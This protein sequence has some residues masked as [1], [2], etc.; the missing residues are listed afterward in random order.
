MLNAKLKYSGSITFKVSNSLDPDKTRTVFGMKYLLVNL[1]QVCSN[2]IPGAQ[3][4]P[5]PG[6][7]LDFKVFSLLIFDVEALYLINLTDATLAS[8]SVL[9]YSRWRP[10]W[11][12]FRLLRPM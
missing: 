3:N 10:R 5:A 6:L 7:E 12:S 11:P 4:G 1:Y 9:K 8:L 2:Y